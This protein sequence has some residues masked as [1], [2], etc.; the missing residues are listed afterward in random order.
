MVTVDFSFSATFVECHARLYMQ[1]YVLYPE[2]RIN[3]LNA[4]TGV[5]LKYFI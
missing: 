4:C 1:L 2:L 5:V 3:F